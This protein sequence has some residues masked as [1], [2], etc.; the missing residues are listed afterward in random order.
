[1]IDFRYLQSGVAA[2]ARAHRGGTMAGHLGAAV[3]AGY[4]YGEDHADLPDEVYQGIEGE[5]DRVIAG[6]ESIWW[7]VKQAGIEPADLF[8]PLEQEEATPEGID[9]IADAL[10]KNV[11]QLRQSGHNVIFASIG[12]RAL[13]DHPD[14]ATPQTIVG[15]RKLTEG[16]QK[17]NAGR[18]YFGKEKGWLIGDQ[19][20]VPDDVKFAPYGSI[21][22][23]VS[24]TIDEMIATAPIKKQGFGGLWHIVNHA[25]AIAELNRF[26]YKKLAQQALPAH[27]NHIEL[28]RSLPDVSSELGAVE[29][30]TED[31][32]RTA[33]WQ[34]M[35]KRDEARLTHRIK[36]LY[37]Y[38]VLRR[39]IE[40]DDKRKQADDSFLYLMS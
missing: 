25:A 4:F 5:L 40:N 26:G 30:A 39:W 8:A 14:F 10:A 35:L 29:K 38:G 36:T 22:E 2:L 3:V 13:Q 28:W 7:N 9:S 34:G 18:G 20:K 19:V 37:G 32:R 24:V 1:M 21:Q 31:P 11:G 6:E 33:Y 27:H 12:I 23:M 15:I 16:F 17:A